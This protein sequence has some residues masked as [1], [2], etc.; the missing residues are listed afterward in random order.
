[1][2]LNG[3]VTKLLKMT[4]D[5]L[6]FCVILQTIYPAFTHGLLEQSSSRAL[7]IQMDMASDQD[8]TI[9]TG[10]KRY[11][12]C[13]DGSNIA[14]TNAFWG[15]V[16]DKVCPSDDGDPVT[17]CE[18]SEDT[19]GLVK[20][21]CEGKNECQ[22][23]AKHTKL[24]KNGTHHCPGVNKYLIVNYTCIPES[25]GVTL[26]DS[27]ETTLYCPSTWNAEL[28]DVFWGRR[29]SSKYC[30]TEEGMECDSSESAAKYLKPLCD[31]KKRCKIRADSAVL[32]STHSA[33]AGMLKY[34]MVN[35]ICRPPSTK[36]SEEVE[37]DDSKILSDTSSKEL[38]GLLEKH[39]NEIKTPETNLKEPKVQPIAAEEKKI[40]PK[41][42]AASAKK[43]S[44]KT[45][46]RNTLG[47]TSNTGFVANEEEDMAN[48]LLN[49]PAFARAIKKQDVTVPSVS[50]KEDS[51][52]LITRP[53]K[54]E[55]FESIKSK[56][57][58]KKEGATMVPKDTITK[59]DESY[60]VTEPNTVRSILARAKEVLKTLDG[61]TN[62]VQSTNDA[63]DDILNK[64]GGIAHNKSSDEKISET[65][66]ASK[67]VANLAQSLANTAAIKSS[68]GKKNL[69]SKIKEAAA[70]AFQ[71]PKPGSTKKLGYRTGTGS[72]GMGNTP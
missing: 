21:Y 10:L 40:E 7:P 8:I 33:C 13:R 1:M 31:G 34:L 72:A 23:E 62:A 65:E 64:R 54:D 42:Y 17:D 29:S 52:A 16:S 61:D 26:C 53:R 68:K 14:V 60:E 25:K 9:C 22:L 58:A 69:S 51:P 59:S 30:G 46:A 18:A 27:T 38:M 28:A 49:G 47:R 55:I 15:R 41:Q 43:A 45:H 50:K 39:L 5:L 70:A 66:N 44:T 3:V 2:V 24:Q 37:D 11:I 35:Y 6:L 12:A 56:P 71:K 32:D 57:A 67:Q 63:A 48:S 36:A 4:M 19:L 20:G